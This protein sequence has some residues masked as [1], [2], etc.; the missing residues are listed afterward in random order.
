MAVVTDERINV[1]LRQFNPWWQSGSIS[2]EFAKEYKR[3]A[4]YEA[5]AGL[6]DPDF[7]RTVILLG[8]RRVGKTTIQ[9]QMIDALLKDGVQANRIVFFSLDHPVLKQAGLDRIL[10]IYHETVYANM[11]AYYFL[12]EIQ[13]EKQWEAWL[14]SLYDLQPKTRFVVTGSA[15]TALSKGSNESGVGRFR[16]ISIPTLSFYEYCELLKLNSSVSLPNNFRPSMLLGMTKQEQSEI[17]LKLSSLQNHFT[18]FLNIGG[19]PELAVAKSDLNAYK[20]I[21][22]DII[23]KVLKQDI[24]EVYTIRS[25]ADLE[26][27]FLYICSVTSDIVSIESMCKE[28]NGVSRPTAESYIGYLISSNLVYKSS[29]LGLGSR[30]VL[31]S[32]PKLYVADSAMR[33]A[34]LMD[35]ALTNPTELGKIVETTVF[36]HV[37]SFFRRNSIDTGYYRGGDKNKEIDIVVNSKGKILIESKYRNQAK[38]HQDSE[39]SHLAGASSFAMVMTKRYDDFGLQNSADGVSI[40]RIPTFAFLYMLGH[41]EKNLSADI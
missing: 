38:L 10:A 39:L 36:R 5:D 32:S 34:I 18:R 9:Y 22:E 28:L 11:D 37:Y 6:K 12:D 20:V 31:K 4:Y 1:V 21:R 7:R 24:P 41:C 13:R 19:L 26:R 2:G 35:D 23:D 29:P 3:F 33:N 30:A 14:K 15:S 17:M 40:L 8:A 27:I 25:L 16:N